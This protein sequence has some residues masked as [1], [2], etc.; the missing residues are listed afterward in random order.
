MPFSR[1]PVLVVDDNEDVRDALTDLLEINGYAT[2]CAANGADALTLL[3]QGTVEPCLILL[4]LNM[5][6]MDG[7]EFRRQQRQ[8]STIAG[9]PVVVYSGVADIRQQAAY[10]NVPHYF[11]K[12]IDLDAL[13]GLVE[14]HC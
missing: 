6:V 1:K 3:K 5:P 4:D 7:T 12:P 2:A 10:L 14:Q 11:Q 13:V 8:D 9:V